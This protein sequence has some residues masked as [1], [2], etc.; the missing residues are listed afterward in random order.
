M[1]EVLH[2]SERQ[3]VYTQLQLVASEVDTKLAAKG[4]KLEEGSKLEE[5]IFDYYELMSDSNS[6]FPSDTCSS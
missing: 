6:D 5:G 3:E 2:S 4:F 1:P